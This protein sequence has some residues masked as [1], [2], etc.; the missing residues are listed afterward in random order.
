MIRHV[1]GMTISSLPLEKYI[2]RAWPMLPGRAV[3]ELLK[4]RDVKRDGVR[5][6]GQDCVRPGD[7]LVLYLPERYNPESAC[8][9]Y[10]DARLLAAVKPQGLPVDVDQDGIGA[11][12]LLNRL[13]EVNPD[14][15]LCHRLD[16]ATGGLVLV[17]AEDEIYARALE[18]FRIHALRKRYLAWTAGGFE[19]SEGTLRAW[20][21]KDARR[22]EVRVVHREMPGAK[23]IETQY[24]VVE[25]RGELARVALEPVT[26]RTHQLRA[27]MADFGHPIL[28]DDKYGRRTLNHAHPG[29]LRLWCA[30]VEIDKGAPL[31]AYRGRRFEAPNPSW[32]EEDWK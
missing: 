31:A 14:A 2:V 32:W 12:T 16:A 13:K 25:D 19:K 27:H 9:V 28:G 26:G 17:A 3:R 20:L 7:E 30:S 4:R 21:L 15:R 11:D 1:V 24:R 6:G 8:L 10:D 22:S 23:P 5:L 18:T 29:M